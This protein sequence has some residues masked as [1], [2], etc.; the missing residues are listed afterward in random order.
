MAMSGH[1]QRQGLC[2]RCENHN[3]TQMLN[4]DFQRGRTFGQGDGM[5][6]GGER[7]CAVADERRVRCQVES[8]MDALRSFWRGGVSADA[9][10]VPHL[11][12]VQGRRR[13]LFGWPAVS[14]S[15]TGK[16]QLAVGIRNCARQLVGRP[17]DSARGPICNSYCCHHQ[18]TTNS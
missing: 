4:A 14:I 10:A 9:A 6:G 3:K 7:R 15:T 2:H 12:F 18:L 5:L 8:C 17:A 16:R 1:L 13:R 11:P